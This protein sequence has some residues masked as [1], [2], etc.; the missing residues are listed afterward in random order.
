MFDS[1]S[2][3]TTSCDDDSVKHFLR[4]SCVGA[5]SKQFVKQLFELV[6]C[7]FGV[8]VCAIYTA[9]KVGRYFQLKSAT[10]ITLSSNVVYQFLCSCDT[11]LSYVG[12]SSRHLGTR[13]QKHLNLADINTKSDIKDHLYDYDKCSSMKHSLEFFKFLKN[14]VVITTMLILKFKKFY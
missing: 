12:M 10:P 2:C 14:C 6:N 5:A 9:Y 4:V 7:K 13:A 11:N 8:E 3:A 1:F